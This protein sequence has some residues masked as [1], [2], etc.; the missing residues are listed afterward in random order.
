MHRKTGIRKRF[1][2]PGRLV[3][4]EVASGVAVIDAAGCGKLAGISMN[5][6]TPGYY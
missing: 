6:S 4:P 2:Q 5:F 3:M 1:I